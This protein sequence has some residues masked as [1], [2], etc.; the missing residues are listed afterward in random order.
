M[1]GEKS[2]FGCIIEPMGMPK[3]RV[4]TVLALGFILGVGVVA[5]SGFDFTVSWPVL[6]LVSIALL[7]AAFLNFLLRC[8]IYVLISFYLIAF[9][10]GFFWTLKFDYETRIVWPKDEVK[11]TGRIVERPELTTRKQNVIVRVG[12]VNIES[13][14]RSCSNCRG[15][16]LRVS[17]PRWPYYGYGDRLE[18]K[19]EIEPPEALEDFDYPRYLKRYPIYGLVNQPTDIRQLPQSMSPYQ[20]VRRGLYALSAQLEEVFSR[21]LPEPHASLGAGIILGQ[22]QNLPAD[23]R[24]QLARAGVIHVIALSGYNISIIMIALGNLSIIYLSRRRVFALGLILAVFFTLATGAAPSIIRAAIFSLLVMFGL[25]LGRKGDSTNLL[26][27][28]ALV[29]L[30][31]NPF[32]LAYDIGF[33]LSFAAFAGLIYLSPRVGKYVAASRLKHL[34]DYVKSPLTETLAAQIAVTPILLATFGQLSFVSPL[35]NFLV[36]PIVPLA[37][38][39]AAL[40]ALAGA[41]IPFFGRIFSDLLWV[42]LEYMIRITEWLGGLRIAAVNL[43]AAWGNL[44]LALYLPLIIWLIICHRQKRKGCV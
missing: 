14:G 35:A 20:R 13:S 9:A 5:P 31:F 33:E 4:F 41:V 26:L 7:C 19:G 29:M 32:L 22:K 37:M 17:L 39:Y 30:V 6:L 12:E 40:A 15:K 21:N 16:L 42:L 24:D 2:V 8:Q 25:T 18:I 44:W 10:L 34:P 38:T 27:L 43:P 28:A 11:I 36:L 3:Y 23:F 1:V